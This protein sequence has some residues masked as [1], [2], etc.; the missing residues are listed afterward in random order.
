[1][2]FVEHLPGPLRAA[3]PRGLVWWQWAALPILFLTAWVIG[4]V[5][6]R[7]TR[8]ILG[9]VARKTRF[10]WDDKL[11]ANIGGPVTLAW[12]AAASHLLLPFVELNDAMS[13]RI[14]K[15]VST[16]LFFA[17]FWFL[18][19]LVAVMDQVIRAS[20]WAQT[21]PGTRSLVPIGSRMLQVAVLAIGVVA[22]LADLGYPVASL[23]A[24]LGIGG[25]AVAL[26][27]QKTVEN[28][29]GTFSI[30][31][32]QP[33]LV[34]DFVS[35]EGVMGHVEVI[36]LR[37][38]RIRTVE[39]TLVTIPNG[40]LADMRI[41]T[42]AARDRIRLACTLGLSYATTG[43]QMRTI[44]AGC[45]E[46][47][48]AHPLVW[49]GEIVVSFKGLGESSLD[50]DLQAWFVTTDYNQ[51]RAIREE[52]LLA[53]MDAVEKAGSSFAFPTRTVYLRGEGLASPRG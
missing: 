2:S 31:V 12:A 53:L 1:M 48:R 27:G 50:I 47:L 22:L 44:L 4:L 40:K 43:A 25:L 18:L 19:R 17:F 11:I 14:A 51:F 13:G 20:P 9:F 46:I 8:V 16:A 34:G 15:G 41:E 42:F 35:V 33:L 28:L 36:G 38:T 29:F 21:R 32:D 26:A 23:I 3:G 30:G 49:P 6:A 45:R 24:G 37:S 10:S 52:L 39:R 5:M 7:L